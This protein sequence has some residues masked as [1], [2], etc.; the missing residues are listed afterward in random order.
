MSWYEI[1][2]IASIP[3]AIIGAMIGAVIKT[4]FNKLI[5]NMDDKEE[6]RSDREF[7]I[8]KGVIAA[9]EVAT[10]QAKELQEKGHVNGNTQQAC[11]YA[12]DVK[13]DIEDFYIRAGSQSLNK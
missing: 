13:H 8:C 3:T 2:G 7:F 1:L 11:D 5:K 6:K 12:T 9:I 4:M 10:T